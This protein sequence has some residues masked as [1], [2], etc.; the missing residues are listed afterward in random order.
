MMLALLKMKCQH[1]QLTKSGFFEF[2]TLFT[3]NFLNGLSIIF[4]KY[5]I[6]VSFVMKVMIEHT[7]VILNK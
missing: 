4:Y 5:D 2:K 3:I 7:N 1:Y 6:F